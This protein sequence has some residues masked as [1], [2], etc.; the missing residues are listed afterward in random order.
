MESHRYIGAVMGDRSW[1]NAWS[2]PLPLVVAIVGA[3]L[4]GYHGLNGQD[5]HDYLRIARTWTAWMDGAPR[6]VMVEH[7]HGYPIAGALLG[8]IMGSEHIALQA[9]SAV[10]M[11]GLLLL[12][13]GLLRRTFPGSGS[14]D[15]FVLLALGSSPFLLRYSLMVMT[16]VPSAVLAF[17]AYVCAVRWWLDRKMKWL[18]LALGAAALA[19]MVRIAVAPMLM[20]L[21]VIVV[22]G[23]RKGRAGRWSV[24]GGVTAVCCAAVLLIIPFSEV[25]QTLMRSPLGEWSPLN[26]VRRDFRLDD[27]DLHY[28]VPNIAYVVCVAG[29]PGFLLMGLGLLPFFRRSD[30]RPAHAR[31][32]AFLLVCY[33]LFIGG[34][35]FQNFRMLVLAQPFV[36]V[37]LYPA[38]ERALVW[39]QEKG[40]RLS[41]A[42]ALVLLAQTVLFVR[43]MA[44]FAHQAAVERDLAAEVNAL[45]P[46]RVYT[47]GMGGALNTY[48]PDVQVTELWYGVIDRFEP[49]S[50]ILVRPTN[51]EEQW[52][53]LAPAINWQRAGQQG[54]DELVIHPDGWVLGRVH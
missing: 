43:A 38:F 23:E 9:I 33:L 53:G 4:A 3:S 42:V 25:W 36:A 48:C 37:L 28:T 10:C 49:G 7:P 32:A 47:H 51:L 52:E 24:I 40:V 16:D 18:V 20:A 44:P 6:P 19:M 12:V 15:L 26:L 50:L 41:W 27:G 5:T 54:V 17:M 35:P 45:P 29:H 8:R 11:L 14:I 34:M 46:S 1:R 13:R 21:A 2:L 22:H 30:L 31:I 39:L